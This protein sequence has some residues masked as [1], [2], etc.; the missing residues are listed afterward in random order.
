MNIV[1]FEDLLDSLGDDL[2]RWPAEQLQAASVLLAESSEARDLLHE[3]QALRGL[4]SPAP[5]RAPPALADRIV[6]DALKRSPPDIQS[7]R[8]AF[9]D[10]AWNL[11]QANFSFGRL[12][13]LSAC[14]VAGLFGGVLHNMTS[15]PK[16]AFEANDFSAYLPSLPYT[17]D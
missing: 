2:S 11:I 3:A 12:A 7:E 9:L 15:A 14:F 1:E 13:F 6:V 16:P 17:V 4:L 8:V 10:R 5:V